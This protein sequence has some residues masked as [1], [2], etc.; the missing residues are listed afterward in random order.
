[1]AERE[2]DS[3]FTKPIEEMGTY[4]EMKSLFFLVLPKLAVAPALFGVWM[5]YE[6]TQLQGAS[7]GIG[8][9]MWGVIGSG[10][11]LLALLM[12]VSSWYVKTTSPNFSIN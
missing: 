1:M 2:F 5:L 10:F 11:F 3:P 8:V 12:I 7:V 6:T 4:E 9:V